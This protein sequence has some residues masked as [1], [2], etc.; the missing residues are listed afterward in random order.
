[1][2]ILP[3]VFIKKKKEKKK[4]NG[5]SAVSLIKKHKFYF[6]QDFLSIHEETCQ[7]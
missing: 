1:M 4:F 7:S 6:S 2:G 3:G 5:S